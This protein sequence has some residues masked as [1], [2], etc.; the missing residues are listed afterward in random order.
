MAIKG[1]TDAESV[2]AR[3]P[4]I[5]KLR[6]GGE[7]KPKIDKRTGQPEKDKFGNVKMIQGE[8]LDYFR[9]DSQKPKAVIT[10]TEHYGNQPKMF[11]VYLPFATPD[12]NFSTWKEAY[13]AS[14]LQHRCDGERV[15]LQLEQGKYV[16]YRKVSESQR[17][18]CP[19]G[20]KEIGRLELILP[21][22]WKSGFIGHVTLETHSKHD[23]MTIMASLRKAYTERQK[24]GMDLRG[25]QFTLYRQNREVSVPGWGKNEGKRVR[26]TKN[27]VIL[28]PSVD[29]A[30][31]QL[32]AMRHDEESL[33]AKM[34]T[35][36]VE[37]VIDVEFHATDDF[38]E[39]THKRDSSSN[40][41]KSGNGNGKPKLTPQQQAEYDA[42]LHKG[43]LLADWMATTKDEKYSALV[44]KWTS[45]YDLA[46]QSHN[47]T[48]KWL[49]ALRRLTTEM[50]QFEPKLTQ[51]EQDVLVAFLEA[52]VDPKV[53]VEVIQHI[54]LQ[55]Q[56]KN[57]QEWQVQLLLYA[58]KFMQDEEG[59][60]LE[61]FV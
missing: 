47:H 43:V 11:H 14:A 29:W 48:S 50:Q 54:Q 46:V 26:V 4:A 3:F 19:G 41:N 52:K 35:D 49:E 24:R 25:M 23:L 34:L 10:F 27:L 15:I 22:M 42:L 28:E 58:A 20:C 53:D 12:D 17:P 60:L 2:I 44:D 21:E 55:N 40:R 8:D 38:E 56:K 9:F 5:G 6:K 57:E 13:S 51:E 30:V 45:G 59:T 36:G 32:E 33:S 1:L 18:E 37:D 16:D 39:E 61:R 31:L 7:Q